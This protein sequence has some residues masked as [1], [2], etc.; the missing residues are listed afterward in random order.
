MKAKSVGESELSRHIFNP[1]ALEELNVQC[2][3]VNFQCKGK[4]GSGGTTGDKQDAMH[5][6]LGVLFNLRPKMHRIY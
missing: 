6:V 5:L 1:I 3:F 4:W 2:Q